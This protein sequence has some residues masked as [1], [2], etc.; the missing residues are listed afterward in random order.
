MIDEIVYYPYHGVSHS[1]QL[2]IFH[3]NSR[4]TYGQLYHDV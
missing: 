1:P 4:Y 2:A 3:N